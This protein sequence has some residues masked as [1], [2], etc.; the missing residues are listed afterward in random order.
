MMITL[1]HNRSLETGFWWLQPSRPSY[2]SLIKDLIAQIS[3]IISCHP[4]DPLHSSPDTWA[5]PDVSELPKLEPSLSLQTFKS[6]Q[7][8]TK[9]SQKLNSNLIIFYVFVDRHEKDP[10]TAA[11]C[12]LGRILVDQAGAVEVTESTGVVGFPQRRATDCC[13]TNIT[14]LLHPAN[15]HMFI[16]KS[17]ICKQDFGGHKQKVHKKNLNRC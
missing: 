4:V 3:W 17:L 16:I 12:D 13:H 15:R 14:S 2:V 8:E 9:W 6:D 5:H 1:Q 10:A 7:K 11:F